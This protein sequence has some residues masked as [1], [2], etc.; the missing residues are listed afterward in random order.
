MEVLTPM[1]A[2]GVGGGCMLG[3]DQCLIDGA[4][5]NRIHGIGRACHGRIHMYFGWRGMAAAV[6]ALSV[7]FSVAYQVSTSFRD[8]VDLVVTGVAQWSPQTATYDG[9][10]ERMEFF[11]HTD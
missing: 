3:R 1:G 9:V 11:Y 10:T 5:P 2:L 8:R 6:I 4:R 7:T